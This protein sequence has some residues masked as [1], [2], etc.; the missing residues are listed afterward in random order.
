M[1]P[2]TVLGST[3]RGTV[4][5]HAALEA[6]CHEGLHAVPDVTD[7]EPLPATNPLY[8][9]PNVLLPPPIAG[10]LGSETRTMTAAVLT[11]LERYAA[12]LPPHSPVTAQSLETL[13]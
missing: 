12:G 8:D 13:T 9:L 5:D 6:A 4:I 11:E 7:P 2:G 10:S 1:P 3:A